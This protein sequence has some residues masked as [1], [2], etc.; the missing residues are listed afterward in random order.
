MDQE[1]KNKILL[2]GKISAEA[3]Q[4]GANLIKPGV[5]LL[6]VAQKVEA[7]IKELG[8]LPAFPVN[9]SLNSI[10]AHYTPIPSD[11][12]IFQD[13]VVKLDVG[14]HVDG[15]T[16]D[17]AVT[18]DLSNKYSDLIK[19]SKGALSAA[20]KVVR[21]G[22]TLG[23]IGRAIEETIQG[24]G[25]EP[26]RNLSGHEMGNFTLHTGQNIPNYNTG[27]DTELREGQLIAIEPFATTGVGMIHEKGE[28]FIHSQTFKKPVRSQI[29][30]D[31]LKIMQ[32][33]NGLPFAT[34][35]LTNKLPM[36][37]I[38]FAFR[39]LNQLGILKSYAPLIEKREGLVSQAEHTVLVED[40]SI[41]TTNI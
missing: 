13:E 37:K 23:E 11:E 8:G 40:K 34:R 26:I 2:A 19:A 38:N 12:S 14:A 16:G 25:F 33:F 27:D 9:I 28:A 7:K 41:T 29:T 21:P 20:I 15:F 22:A 5:K 30:R 35:W 10:A 1:T 18:I 39:E 3:L 31:V 24:F 32:P 6:D 36:F 4:Y 17:N